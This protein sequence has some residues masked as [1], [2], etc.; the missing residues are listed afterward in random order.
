MCGENSGMVTGQ[1]ARAQD[2]PHLQLLISN[3][4]SLSQ[5]ERALVLKAMGERP[6][7]AARDVVYAEEAYALLGLDRLDAP[8]QAL[9]RLIRRGDLPRRKLNARLAFTR[10]EIDH[11]IQHGSRKSRRGRPPGSKNRKSA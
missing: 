10:A 2:N 1:M 5:D 11:L 7:A 6:P 4:Q 9:Q 3:L 8:E